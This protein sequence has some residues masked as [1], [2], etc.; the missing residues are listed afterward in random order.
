[1]NCD[2]Y[3]CLHAVTRDFFNFQAGFRLKVVNHYMKDK[4]KVW[5]LINNYYQTFICRHIAKEYVINYIESWN[6][7]PVR[8]VK[9]LS[10]E[11]SYSK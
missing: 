1:M 11:A 7:L 3:F 6:S 8:T 9:P 2:P 4:I 5:F 10:V